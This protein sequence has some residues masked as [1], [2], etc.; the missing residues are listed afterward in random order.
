MVTVS[1]QKMSKSLGNF[2]TVADLRE[3]LPGGAIRLALLSAHY[4]SNLDWTED[5]ET[6]SL[7]AWHKF[8]SLAVDVTPSNTIPERLLTALADDLNTAK[9]IAELHRLHSI[10]DAAGLAAS[11]DILGIALKDDRHLH[12]DI[13]ERIEDL[14]SQRASARA[15]RDFA[16]SDAIRDGLASA[17]I[18]LKDEVGGTTWDKTAH[19]NAGSVMAIKV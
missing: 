11:L 7:D 18:A 15:A 4:R 1:G 6:R 12:D 2:T 13:A 3:R 8:T 19:F 16:T 10:G 14:I 5:L 9:A 17:G